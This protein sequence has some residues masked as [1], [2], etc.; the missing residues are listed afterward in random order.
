MYVHI[1]E[2]ERNS[3][4]IKRDIHKYTGIYSPNISRCNI[5]VNDI[6]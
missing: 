6:L 5:A 1:S 2:L 3:E 4:Y